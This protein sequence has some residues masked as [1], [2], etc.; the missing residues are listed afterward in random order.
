MSLWIFLFDESLSSCFPLKTASFSSLS[1]FIIAALKSLST[2]SNM[3]DHSKVISVP[4]F[5]FLYVNH[6]FLY[7]GHGFLYVSHGF[8]FFAYSL[9]FC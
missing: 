9:C 4:C 1:I 2:M 7:V 6:G 8:L 3:W 5:C